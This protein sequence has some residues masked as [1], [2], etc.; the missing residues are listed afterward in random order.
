MPVVSYYVGFLSGLLAL[1]ATLRSLL[2]AGG[3][4]SNY[5]DLGDGGIVWQRRP[6]LCPCKLSE[7]LINDVLGEVL[8]GFGVIRHSGR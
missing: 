4:T 8:D 1:S 7:E 2:E 5:A 3:S 6:V